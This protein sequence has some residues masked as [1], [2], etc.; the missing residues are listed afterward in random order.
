MRNNTT[1]HELNSKRLKEKLTKAEN[2]LYIKKDDN[3]KLK[4]KI[5][6]LKHQ[7]M[8]LELTEKKL[9]NLIVNKE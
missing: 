3:V 7:I 9:R 4:N 5:A 8:K 2:E 1:H 6:A